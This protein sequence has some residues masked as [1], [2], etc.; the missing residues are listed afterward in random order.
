ML[1]LRCLMSVLLVFATRSTA[2]GQDYSVEIINEPAKPDKVDEE[3]VKQFSG[4]GYR[5]KR[6]SRRTVC[7]IWL[8]KKWEVEADFKVTEERRYPFYPGQLIGL[9]HFTRRGSDFRDQSFS[10]GWYTLRFD[11]QPVDGNHVGTSP[12]RD[13][14]L[15][16]AAAQDEP[17]KQWSQEDLLEVSA[18]AA[19]SSHPGM[20]CLQDP[21]KDSKPRVRHHEQQDWWI[22]HLLGKG[23]SN[24][25]EHEV[26]LDLVVAGH[27]AE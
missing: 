18:E 12:T 5:V 9:L 13:F 14:L 24:H 16:V 7:E 3:L 17:G 27:A 25:E 19:G 23:V 11:L 4:Q 6:D 26:A 21:I 2:I 1:N 15:L 8:C 20:L 10:K 22:L